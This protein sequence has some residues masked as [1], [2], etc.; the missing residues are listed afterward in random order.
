MVVVLQVNHH[1]ADVVFLMQV[2]PMHF[3][4]INALSNSSEFPSKAAILWL[5]V[6]LTFF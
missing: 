5:M 3:Q 6:Y 2:C 4:D 1:A